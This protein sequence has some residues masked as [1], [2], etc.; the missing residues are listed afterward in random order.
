LKTFYIYIFYKPRIIGKH[1][2]DIGGCWKGPQ[3]FI[4]TVMK[5]IKKD[6]MGVK[7]LVVE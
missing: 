5:N 6:I 7:I 3:K 2:K 1:R 4:F